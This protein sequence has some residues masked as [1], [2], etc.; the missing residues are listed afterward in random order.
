MFPNESDL[1]RSSS[2]IAPIPESSQ[3][4]RRFS[5]YGLNILSEIDLPEFLPRGGNTI[6]PDVVVSYDR[7]TGWKAPDGNER[8]IWSVSPQDARFWFPAV[9]GFR[10]RGGKEILLSPEP[11]VEERFLR[12]YVEGMMMASVLQQ[13]G[14]FVLHASVVQ[15]R[16]YAVGFLG[17]IGAG[18]SS[19][20]AALHMRGHAVV[21]DDN[22]AIDLSAPE[23]PVLPAFPT[24]KVFPK[25]AT[26]LGY[27]EDS[28]QEMHSSQPK[29]ARSVSR[30]FPEK[31]VPLKR[32]YVL[33][34]GAEQDF[35]A[36]SRGEYTLEMIRNSVPTRWGQTGDAHHLKQCA[37]MSSLIPAW[38][39]K[40]F[41]AL[42]E[43]P[44]L[45]RRIE[46]HCSEACVARA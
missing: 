43:L 23:L 26:S 41:D 42:E 30:S 7:S 25:I 10:V 34:R 16:D 37:R 29:K 9:G 40:T 33:T 18:K 36:L 19:T 22:A 20:A 11:D 13:R 12:L 38:R 3:N 14:Y 2:M 45:A 32:L 27:A 8:A 39:V 28:L 24:V 1:F 17:H 15:I 44:E 46:E 21:T 31:P 5:A 6:A 4:S 35:T